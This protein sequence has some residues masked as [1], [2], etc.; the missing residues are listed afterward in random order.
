M[1][2][3]EIRPP[4]AFTSE[5]AAEFDYPVSCSICGSV[6]GVGKILLGD[7]VVDVESAAMT[8][9][10]VE[11]QPEMIETVMA[12]SADEGGI[13]FICHESCAAK[14]GYEPYRA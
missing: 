11:E 13:Y 10:M 7:R 3:A 5:E 12:A 2:R 6:P 8:R 4:R 14:S 1:Q 9:Q